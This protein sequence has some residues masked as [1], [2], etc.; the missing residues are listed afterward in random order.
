MIYLS[1]WSCQ[2]IL[3]ELE[4]WNND[5]KRRLD[6]MPTFRESFSFSYPTSDIQKCPGRPNACFS[7]WDDSM[8]SVAC[9]MWFRVSAANK[10][11][12][13]PGAKIDFICLG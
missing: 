6:F 10:I 2:I 12:L 11:D 9:L 5:E 1:S 3:I 8:M 7:F 4:R 13:P